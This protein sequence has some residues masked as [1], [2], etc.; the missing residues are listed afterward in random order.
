MPELSILCHGRMV[1]CYVKSI[2][3]PMA[4]HHVQAKNINKSL[5]AL[6]QVIWALA[7][8]QKHIPQLSRIG[9]A[10][11]WKTMRFFF[12]STCVHKWLQTLHVFRGNWCN[13]LIYPLVI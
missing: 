10:E 9:S 8:K 3:Y 12:V 6:G 13:E 7:H 11:S 5:L 4:Y 1:P 2:V